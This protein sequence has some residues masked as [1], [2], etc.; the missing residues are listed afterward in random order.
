MYAQLPIESFLAMGR[1][2]QVIPVSL[3]AIILFKRRVLAH[4][5]VSIGSSAQD[6][7]V[8]VP[9]A[10]DQW[11]E[12]VLESVACLVAVEK[13]SDAQARDSAAPCVRR[14]PAQYP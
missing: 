14:A 2:P 9:A 10:P 11:G 4:F 8:G 13:E 1:C 6:K 12:P 5:V 7:S 3:G